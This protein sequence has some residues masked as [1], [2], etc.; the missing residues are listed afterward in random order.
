MTQPQL[1]QLLQSALQDGDKDALEDYLAAHSNLPGP[2][3]NLELLHGFADAVGNI[4]TQPD[5]PVEQLEGLLDGWASLDVSVNE[6]RVMLPCAAVLAYGQ[7]GASRPDSWEDEIAKIHRAAA[8]LRWRV[9][10]MVAAALQRMLAADWTRTCAA[11]NRWLK[12]DDPLVI[13]AVAAGVAEP[14]LLKDPSHAEQAVSLQVRAVEKLAAFPPEE[15]RNENVR[16]LRQALGYTVSVAVAAA[17]DAGFR[18]LEQLAAS[19][20]SDVRWVVRENLK[21]NRLSPWA[22]R[23]EAVQSI[24]SE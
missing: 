21:K 3:G 2:R 9:R 16:T 14:P 12:E 4:I 7:A 13:R 15:R 6:P 8:D 24:L 23:V 10:E 11:L 22:N 20:D 19:G 5:P 1:T 18:L 17:P